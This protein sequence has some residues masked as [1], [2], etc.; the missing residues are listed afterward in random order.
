MA[1]RVL[2]SRD[3]VA[4]TNK[5]PPKVFRGGRPGARAADLAAGHAPVLTPEDVRDFRAG[6]K[7]VP[8]TV[9]NDEDSVDGAAGRESAALLPAS[10]EAN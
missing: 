9:P 1:P 8:L 10:R 6:P 5:V 4:K 2:P 3:R 7:T